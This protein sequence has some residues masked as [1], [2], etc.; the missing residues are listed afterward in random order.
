MWSCSSSAHKEAVQKAGSKQDLE[1]AIRDGRV[2]RSQNKG[3]ATFFFPRWEY[4][5]EKVYKEK[6]RGTKKKQTAEGDFNKLDEQNMGFEWGAEAHISSVFGKYPQKGPLSLPSP[7]APSLSLGPL[8][9]TNPTST[10]ALPFSLS[11]GAN[12]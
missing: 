7:T 5:R 4:S 12:C 6:L 8:P 1:I 3:I 10:S 2:V 11:G 9:L